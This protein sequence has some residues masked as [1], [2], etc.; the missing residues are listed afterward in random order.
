MV[1]LRCLI[2]I[3]I[4]T[5]MVSCRSFA[6]DSEAPKTRPFHMGFT[7]WPADLTADG[8]KTAVDFADTHGDIISVMFIGGIP[9]QEALDGRPFSKDVQDNFRYRPAAGEKLFLSI[10]PLNKDRKGLAPYWG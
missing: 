8:V 9:W 6:E 7:R 3:A 1:L 10:S 4:S 2:F 5:S